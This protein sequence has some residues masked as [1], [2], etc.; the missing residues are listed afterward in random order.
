MPACSK[1][2]YLG[3][4]MNSNLSSNLIKSVFVCGMCFSVLNSYFHCT[5]PYCPRKEPDIPS[6]YISSS[7]VNFTSQTIVSSASVVGSNVV[8]DTTTTTTI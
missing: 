2:K 5:N 7:V 1:S 8:S 6:N 4:F 3:N